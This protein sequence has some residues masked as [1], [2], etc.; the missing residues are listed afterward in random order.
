MI[1]TLTQLVGSQRKALTLV[2]VSRSTWHYRHNPRNRVWDPMHQ[3][4]RAYETRISAAD[5]EVIG[6]YILAGWADQNSVDHAF[7][8]AWDAGIMLASRRTWWRIAADLED[9]MLRPKVPTKAQTRQRRSDKPVLKATG[10]GQVWRWDISDL[11]SPWRSVVFKVYSAIDIF[12]RE[13]VGYRVE[14]READ[15]LAV[16]MFEQAIVTYGAPTTVHADSGPAMKSNVLRDALTAHGVELTHNRPYVSNDNPF[17]ESAFRTMKYRPGYPRIFTTLD[18]AR[19]YIDDYVPWYNTQHKHSGIALFSPSQVHD[20][21]WKH[22]WH[23]RDTALQN[24]YKKHPARFHQPPVTP[25]PADHVGIN[26]P[27]KQPA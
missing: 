5:R 18:T 14:D 9:Q 13:I 25:A 27:E 3:S 1:H 20:G 8:T 12:S 11:Y 19:A 7:A 2:G 17:S 6:E 15:H 22:V 26:L 4:Q 16:E 21:S 23:T 10:P 24:Y